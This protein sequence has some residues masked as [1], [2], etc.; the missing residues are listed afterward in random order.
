MRSF[1]AFR[2]SLRLGLKKMLRAKAAARNRKYEK[3]NQCT[4]NIVLQRPSFMRP[5]Q[6]LADSISVFSHHTMRPA[7]EKALKF[8]FVC[9]MMDRTKDLSV[10]HLYDSFSRRGRFVVMGDHD[11]S[12]VQ[13]FVE[14]L[15]HA[16]NQTRIL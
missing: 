2:G 6:D 8:R 9:S 12:L 1:S 11:H 13:F 10:A 7:L 3:K 4:E 15:K 5:A 16:Q 14:L